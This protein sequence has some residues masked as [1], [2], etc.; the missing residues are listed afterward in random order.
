MCACLTKT[1][2]SQFARRVQQK[3]HGEAKRRRANLISH[4]KIHH[5]EDFWKEYEAACTAKPRAK[6]GNH[7]KRKAT[8]NI[9]IEDA[10]DKKQKFDRKDPRAKALG[11][12]V[13]QFIT[14]GDQ[15]FSVVAD[16]GF[17]LLIQHVE[18]DYEIPSRLYFSDTCLPALYDMLA[19]HVHTLLT[20]SDANYISFTID[21]SQASMLIKHASAVES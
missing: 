7:N 20:K 18:P 17:C 15:P 11:D 1:L 13:I 2:H 5:S 8:G 16:I 3:F 6:S 4:L 21:M 12:K 10:F 19:T 14:T 9:T